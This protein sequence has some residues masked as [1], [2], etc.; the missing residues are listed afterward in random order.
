MFPNRLYINGS[1]PDTVIH[2]KEREERLRMI[3]T[4]VVRFSFGEVM[5]RRPLAAKL[6]AAGIPRRAQ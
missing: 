3:C 4:D 6:D 5:E 2:E 1:L